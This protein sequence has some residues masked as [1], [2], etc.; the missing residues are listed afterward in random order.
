MKKT[1]N[2]ILF[3]LASPFIVLYLIINF[4][5]KEIS[6]LQQKLDDFVNLK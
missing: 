4:N 5:K 6:D 2:N 3:F 1:I